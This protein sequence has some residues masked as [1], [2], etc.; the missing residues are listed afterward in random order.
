MYTCGFRDAGDIGKVC[1]RQV[2]GD[3]Q[4]HRRVAAHLH[5]TGQQSL[6]R[7]R[8]LQVAQLFGVG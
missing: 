3:L 8:P 1:I 5:D 2:G 7:C 6:K 4:E